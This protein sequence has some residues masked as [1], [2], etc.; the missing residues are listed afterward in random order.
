MTWA[1]PQ[2]RTKEKPQECWTN[3]QHLEG[4]CELRN[5]ISDEGFSCWRRACNKQGLQLAGGWKTFRPRPNFLHM[6]PT[7]VRVGT[8]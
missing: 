6:L 7:K 2:S 1:A 4:E 8:F 5:Q 3:T